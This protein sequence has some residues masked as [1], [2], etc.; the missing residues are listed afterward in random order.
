MT[1]EPSSTLK[2]IHLKNR[3]DFFFFLRYFMGPY[4]KIFVKKF[5]LTYHFFIININTSF[6][7]IS[8]Y[9]GQAVRFL[10]YSKEC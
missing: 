7:I 2:E 9:E 6:H 4:F 10:V 3:W 1:L 8:R 5:F